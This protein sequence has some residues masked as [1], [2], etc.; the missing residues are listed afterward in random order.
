LKE[1]RGL[2]AL[3]DLQTNSNQPAAVA[4]EKVKFLAN[5]RNSSTRRSNDDDHGDARGTR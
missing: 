3:Q 5:E 2:I 4:Q 1:W